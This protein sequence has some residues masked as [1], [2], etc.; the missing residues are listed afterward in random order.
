MAMGRSSDYVMATR[1]PERHW[2]VEF[3]HWQAKEVPLL[4]PI[5]IVLSL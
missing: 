4:L 1:M 2:L 3:L 5:C